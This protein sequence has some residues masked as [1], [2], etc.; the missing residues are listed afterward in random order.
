MS[1]DKPLAPGTPFGRYEIV[2]QLGTGGMATVYEAKHL[3]LNKRVAL[4]TLHRWLALRTEIVKR[5]VLEARMASRI[6]HPHV[7]GISDIG[8]EQEVPFM[9]MDLLEG[10]ELAAVIDRQ[11]AMPLDRIADMMLPLVSAVAAAHDAGILHRDLKPEN[12]FLA[13]RRPHGQYLSL[14]H[15]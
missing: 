8:I 4:K 12:I 14:I 10:E 7:L 5:F 6:Q 9:A 15:I 3:D 2:R 1:A 13:Q 11:G